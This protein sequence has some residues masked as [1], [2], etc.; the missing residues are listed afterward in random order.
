MLPFFDQRFIVFV[1]GVYERLC[2]IEGIAPKRCSFEVELVPTCVWFLELKIV[3][4]YGMVMSH[5]RAHVVVF[6]LETGF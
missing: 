4:G 6:D 5:T 1:H 2:L 3:V